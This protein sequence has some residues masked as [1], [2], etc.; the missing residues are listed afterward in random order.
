[1]VPTQLLQNGLHVTPLGIQLGTGIHRK[2]SK[3]KGKEVENEIGYNMPLA[4]RHNFFSSNNQ[5]AC[6]RFIRMYKEDVEKN[7]SLVACI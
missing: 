2:I 4:V 7:I 3:V 5:E 6:Y 1:M